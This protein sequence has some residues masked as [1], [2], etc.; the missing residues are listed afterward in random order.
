DKVTAF[1]QDPHFRHLLGQRESTFS[2][3]DALDNGSWIILN[4]SKGTLGEQAA[5]LGSLFLA[6][7]KAAVFARRSRRPFTLFLDEVQNLVAMDD[8][9]ETL[10]S[11]ARKFAVSVLSANQYL[12]QYPPAMRASILAVN[13]HIFFRLSG[14][15]AQAMAAMCDGG[16][17]LARILKT[18]PQRRMVVRIG[19]GRA[20]EARV[21]HLE[22]PD[23]DTA[24][25]I[26]RCRDRF[27]RPRRE[28]EAAIRL[29]HRQ[30]R[31]NQDEVLD[32]WD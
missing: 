32:G 3:A 13:S 21:P 22:I 26:R 20:V 12:G 15:D 30:A 16:T 9:L 7:L 25:L 17:S 27:C 4:L 1:T 29:R 31:Q 23:E 28:V 10:F 2:L 11:E 19:G 24:D 5:T 8:S 18:L 6:K 14:K